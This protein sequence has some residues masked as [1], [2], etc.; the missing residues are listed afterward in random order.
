VLQYSIPESG[1]FY[2]EVL[3]QILLRFLTLSF[4]KTSEESPSLS[5]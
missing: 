4:G 3:E 5:P 1:V 2:S